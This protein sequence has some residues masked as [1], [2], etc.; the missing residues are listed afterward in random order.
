MNPMTAKPS[1]A[2]AIMGSL[3]AA[4]MVVAA[5][6]QSAPPLR[7]VPAGAPEA[8]KP[9]AKK[10]PAKAPVKA[11]TKVPTKAPAKAVAKAPAAKAPAGK[12]P[13]A[14]APV[15]KAPVAKA[16][17][18]KAATSPAAKAAA[19]PAAKAAAPP[20]AT[21]PAPKATPAIAPP[22]PRPAAT[23]PVVQAT[24]AAVPASSAA[25]WRT[26]D[27]ENAVVFETTKG[28][29]IVELAPELA[30]NHVVRIKE[31]ARS[32]F[33]DGLTFHRVI[34]GFMAQGGDPT[35][36]G[37]GNSDKPDLAAEFEFRRGGDSPFVRA[38]ERGGQVLGFV[39]SVPVT[40]QPD[41]LMTRMRDS[42]VSAYANH[43]PGVASMARA[44]PENS[45]NSQFFLMR[46]PYPTLD[47]RYTVWGRAVVG[48]DVI[49]ALKIG[50]PGRDPAN[51]SGFKPM[52]DPDRMTRVRVMADIPVGER[53]EIS[54]Q[55]TDGP[56]FQARLAQVMETRGAA[57][58]N[59][60][61][62]PE[63]RISQ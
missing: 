31:L 55:R 41:V 48:L 15:A 59:C 18:A 43:C 20:T 17:A 4:F 6:A 24:S 14:K 49:R 45:A 44:E 12:A 27:P 25:E 50:E 21:P 39:R 7:I 23:A 3:A 2:A 60:D 42:R 9:P 34:E 16:P 54:I 40:S 62:T 58:S 8:Q 52:A 36:V 56:A 30:P 10:A 46:G 28:R 19:P 47:R 61:I 13:V 57:F 53:P 38:V 29:V 33:Y 32:G 35:G 26:L 63:V 51:P 37:S 5:V 11:P 22:P 1:L